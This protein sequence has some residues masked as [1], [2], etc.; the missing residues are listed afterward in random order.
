MNNKETL[1]LIHAF[2][3]ARRNDIHSLSTRESVHR[4]VLLLGR[5]LSHD[6]LPPI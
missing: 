5:V 1:Q 2:N 4:R 3:W 6:V